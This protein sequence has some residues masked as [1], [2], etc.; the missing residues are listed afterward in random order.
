[1]SYFKT[2]SLHLGKLW[3]VYLL[4]LEHEDPARRPRIYIGSG[5]ETTY[6]I[7]KRM[8][9][10]DKRT[11]TGVTNSAIPQYVETSLREGYDITHKCLL[12]WA[13]LPMASDVFQLR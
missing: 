6:G 8:S 1:M 11:Q 7:R 10:Y 5:T 3:A 2:F 12:C 13:A 4:V 9:Q